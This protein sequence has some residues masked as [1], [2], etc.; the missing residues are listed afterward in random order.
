MR[1]PK[2]TS[3]VWRTRPGSPACVLSRLRYDTTKRRPSRACTFIWS[4]GPCRPTRGG[5]SL[6]GI[7]DPCGD[8]LDDFFF[9]PYVAVIMHRLARIAGGFGTTADQDRFLDRRVF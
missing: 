5:S 6:G 1:I 3:A 9:H 7:L 8:Q 2:P 4:D